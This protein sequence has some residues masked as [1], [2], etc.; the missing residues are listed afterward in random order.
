MLKLASKKPQTSS[1]LFSTPVPTIC[2]LR[3]RN[4]CGI[5]LIDVLIGPHGCEVN[6]QGNMK[7]LEQKVPEVLVVA[8]ANAAMKANRHETALSYVELANKTKLYWTLDK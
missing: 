6:M 7:P 4:G 1:A 3:N 5:S 2:V 8:A